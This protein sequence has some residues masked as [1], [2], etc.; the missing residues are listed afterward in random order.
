MFK[1]GDNDFVAISKIVEQT[2]KKAIK[3]AGLNQK[4]NTT[5]RKPTHVTYNR[6]TGPVVAL[7]NLI[8]AVVR[9]SGA[10]VEAAQA[11]IKGAGGVQLYEDSTEGNIIIRGDA[12]ND[13]M[14]WM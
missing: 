6:G 12:I 9:A 11:K 13:P 10:Y 14:Y 8:K 4:P 3:D 2:V 5:V 1:K 7:Q